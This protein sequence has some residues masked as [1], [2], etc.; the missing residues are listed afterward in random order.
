[1]PICIQPTRYRYA[2]AAI[3][4]GDNEK[5]IKPTNK[6]NTNRP[7][8]PYKNPKLMARIFEK[9]LSPVSKQHINKQNSSTYMAK[10]A[11]PILTVPPLLMVFVLPA[12][13]S[14]LVP[15]EA[16]AR[17]RPAAAPIKIHAVIYRRRVAI[18][19]FFICSNIAGSFRVFERVMVNG[20][21]IWYW[22]DDWYYKRGVISTWFN[23]QRNRTTTACW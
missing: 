10:K 13:V 16:G 9:A 12:T 4:K 21:G 2:I 1:M 23:V 17:A 18:C 19:A 6:R 14:L 3:P 22:N 7:I 20:K 5:L 15:A 11:V 8:R